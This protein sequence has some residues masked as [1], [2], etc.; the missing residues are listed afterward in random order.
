LEL[1]GRRSPAPA[2]N[3]ARRILGRRR[4]PD[5]LLTLNGVTSY[6][7]D[8][9]RLLGGVAEGFCGAVELSSTERDALTKARLGQG[10]FSNRVSKLEPACGSRG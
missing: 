8:H 10:L 6:A 1:L 5:R 7:N 9:Y 2:Q 4:D 3:I